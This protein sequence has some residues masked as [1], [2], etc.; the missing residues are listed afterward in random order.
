[1]ADPTQDPTQDTPDTTPSPALT[2]DAE[3]AADVLYRAGF[4][5]AGTA[6]T[7]AGQNYES[8]GFNPRAVNPTSGAYGLSQ[9]LGSR[10]AGLQQYAQNT[11]Q[12]LDDIATQE[13]YAVNEMNTT[14]RASGDQIRNAQDVNQ[15]GAT[16][17]HGFE[18]PGAAAEQKEI[19]AVQQTAQQTLPA[20]QAH[21][22]KKE[23]AA[24]DAASLL[25]RT[26]GPTGGGAFDHQPLPP[27]QR[28]PQA[29]PL[30]DAS[31]ALDNAMTQQQAKAQQA[32]A[33]TPQTPGYDWGSLGS[34]FSEVPRGLVRGIV[35]KIGLPVD[36]A[37][38]VSHYYSEHPQ[39]AALVGMAGAGMPAANLSDVSNLPV[40]EPNSGGYRLPLGTQDIAK[41]IKYTT[42]YDINQ[43]DK[44][45]GGEVLGHMAEFVGAGASPTGFAHDVG[46]V[47]E[48]ADALSKTKSLAG[49]LFHHV[50]APASISGGLDA[51]EWA[52]DKATG[53]QPLAEAVGI[54]ARAALAGALIAGLGKASGAAKGFI[55]NAP[56]N[57]LDQAFEAAHGGNAPFEKAAAAANLEN[58]S[59]EGLP[60]GYE[61]P[62]ALRTGS[63]PLQ[64][65][66]FN[67]QKNDLRMH[68]DFAVPG[69]RADANI[70]AMEGMRP[71]GDAQDA[72]QAVRNAQAS[73][74]SMIDQRV[75]QAKDLAEQANVIASR[76]P[77]GAQLVPGGPIG[78]QSGFD[79][80]HEYVDQLRGARDD[81]FAHAD[82]QWQ[83]ARAQGFT[84]APA[85]VSPMYQKLEGLMGDNIRLQQGANFPW[86]I[87][88][89]LY[90]SGKPQGMFDKLGNRL[91]GTIGQDQLFG[92]GTT[93]EQ[94]KGVDSRLGNAIRMEQD[95]IS[96]PGN[97][98]NPTLLRNL[99]QVRS[100][101]WQAIDDGAAV[102]GNQNVLRSAMDATAQA[103]KTFGSGL[104]ARVL[105]EQGGA[106]NAPKLMQTYLGNSQNAIQAADMFRSAMEQ[107]TG[108][109]AARLNIGGL[110]AGDPL[111]GSTPQQQFSRS[112]ADWM[113][114]DYLNT[115]AD[116]GAAAGQKWLTNHAGFFGRMQGNPDFDT[117]H[118]ELQGYSQVHNAL[119]PQVLN[120]AKKEQ[121]ELDHSAAQQFLGGDAGPRL[122]TVFKSPN[123]GQAMQGLVDD[124]LAHGSGGAFRGLQRMVY[125]RVMNEAMTNDPIRPNQVYYSGKLAKNFI[126]QNQTAFNTLRQ[127]DPQW[128][129]NL[130]RLVGTLALE[131]RGRLSPGLELP[132]VAGPSKSG[133]SAGGSLMTKTV[134]YVLAHTVGRNL[135]AA[136]LQGEA[137][138]SQFGKEL[139]QNLPGK[140][141]GALNKLDP[142]LAVRNALREAMFDPEKM[143]A[144]LAPT[145]G[146]SGQKWAHGIEPWLQS[147]GVELPQPWLNPQPQSGD[148]GNGRP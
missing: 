42:G 69:G 130:D 14:E 83:A 23:K 135:P 112:L 88:N 91:P 144:L 84:S 81:A 33:Q 26:I 20:I 67:L 19:P 95:A 105:N 103:Y 17:I 100:T 36:I 78:Q 40:Y 12:P 104:L 54:G 53:N 58:F 145:T 132:G 140:L 119:L 82:D 143:R 129:G 109:A 24:A 43:Q 99:S 31:S 97:R 92:E 39:D 27:T 65:M 70:S 75:M 122:D 35:S 44:S 147:V 113:R 8:A 89:D 128:S 25:D 86:N 62:A 71:E 57:T 21:F 77:S 45:I 6:S 137:L 76:T 117:L 108:A 114:Q 98:G 60:A 9:D 2:P 48:A 5:P 148:Q 1:M 18:R 37:N 123:P 146:P 56:G 127:A 124:T 29:D 72:V 90:T 38:W 49:M 126:D 64:Q 133:W 63:A 16:Y 139:A 138:S 73:R 68:N 15:G 11:Q 121:A 28:S 94:L 141:T 41:A 106:A 34:A 110:Q 107:R 61:V 79:L 80:A 101:V 102:S 13:R 47:G 125:D 66:F 52:V 22:A 111:A 7:L 3:K 96:A 131:D 134:Q 116:N 51:G 74:Q 55:E 50:L 136:G 32:Q 30:A 59:G 87:V 118:A 142:Q 4:S 115:H 120:A 10:K 85:P 46:A 93:L